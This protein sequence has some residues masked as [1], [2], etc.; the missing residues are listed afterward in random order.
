MPETAMDCR[1]LA[2]SGRPDVSPESRHSALRPHLQ[3][4][5]IL[6]RA[7]S[8]LNG[9]QPELPYPSSWLLRVVSLC[10]IT[11]RLWRVPLR[12]V[13]GDAQTEATS[14]PSDITTLVSVFPLLSILQSISVRFLE[15]LMCSYRF[16]SDQE[17]RQL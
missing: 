3:S 1:F 12:G 13:P 7:R 15:L 11:C 2:G 8:P 5:L 16:L 10:R 14:P 9:F 17:S 6:S 4:C